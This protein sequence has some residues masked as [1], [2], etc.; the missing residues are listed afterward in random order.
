MKISSFIAENSKRRINF[1]VTNV[2]FWEPGVILVYLNKLQKMV[3]SACG[4][5]DVVMLLKITKNWAENII[6]LQ[7][8]WKM[9]SVNLANVVPK[10][11]K[12]W[13]IDFIEN[14]AK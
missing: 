12:V 5:K 4:S 14:V 7:K 2:S 3:R 10:L 1:N 6:S 13:H 8:L 11:A 9:S